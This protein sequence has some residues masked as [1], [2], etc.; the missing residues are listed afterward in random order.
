M[1]L[2]DGLIVLAM[3]FFL[4]TADDRRANG[5]DEIIRRELPWR[6]ARGIVVVPRL[7]H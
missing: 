5:A 7:M 3:T 4:H 2:I 1:Y 6:A